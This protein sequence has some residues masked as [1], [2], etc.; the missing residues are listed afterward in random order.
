MVRASRQLLPRGPHG[1]AERAPLCTH[2]LA[3]H[4]VRRDAPIE[5][6]EAGAPHHRGVTQQELRV[7]PAPGGGEG[8]KG[9][10]EGQRAASVPQQAG[11]L[12][13]RRDAETPPGPWKD[14]WSPR[15]G[16]GG[17][18]AAPGDKAPAALPE[19]V[20]WGRGL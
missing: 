3:L 12:R 19:G 8:V 2:S 9:A 1:L 17:G 18:G 13:R 10:A 16:R 14:A 4:P 15:R 5:H 20:A 7:P 11:S 6:R